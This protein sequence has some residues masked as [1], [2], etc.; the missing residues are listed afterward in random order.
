VAGSAYWWEH[1]ILRDLDYILDHVERNPDEP[2]PVYLA[3]GPRGYHHYMLEAIRRGVF[4][5]EE[6][7]R[8]LR[9]V[10]VPWDLFSSDLPFALY[11]QDEGQWC[12][13]PDMDALPAIGADGREVER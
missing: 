11:T 7:Y 12:Q 9:V 13:Y 10:R 1:E 8:G 5:P 4:S 2:P 6:R 3:L